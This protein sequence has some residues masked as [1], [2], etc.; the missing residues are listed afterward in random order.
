VEKVEPPERE[1]D[2]VIPYFFD[3]TSKIVFRD[4][5][6]PIHHLTNFNYESLDINFD[7]IV[8][9]EVALQRL[10]IGLQMPD[11]SP[12]LIVGAPGTGKSSVLRRLKKADWGKIVQVD[13]THASGIKSKANL[14]QLFADAASSQP[15]LVIID[16]IDILAPKSEESAFIDSLCTHIE[17]SAKYQIRI[18]A[19]AKRR[20]DIHQQFNYHFPLTIDLRLPTAEDRL[21]ITSALFS[22][23]HYI[24]PYVLDELVDRTHAFTAS[25][26]YNLWKEAVFSATIRRKLALPND[27][28]NDVS[29]IST[30]S[31]STTSTLDQ[32]HVTKADIDH[33][34]TIVHASAMKEI[35]IDIPK[36]S[37]S[38][39]GGA[40]KLKRAL[41]QTAL[42]T[43]G[44]SY[45]KDVKHSLYTYMN[46]ET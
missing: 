42:L 9:N 31:A 35:Y 12:I 24:D 46:L 2:L 37:W 40:E 34:L 36:V 8:G 26:L 6:T 18:V 33:A 20:V 32:L 30:D 39:I 3:H 29:R 44:V 22:T 27:L 38:D 5:T 13:H 7:G 41:R 19:T 45:M 43:T 11:N 14:S 17:E 1:K 28:S 15:A 4:T 25:D 10:V 16:N 21:G 23:E